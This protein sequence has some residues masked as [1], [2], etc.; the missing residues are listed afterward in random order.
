MVSA[1]DW[2]DCDKQ[3][4]PNPRRTFGDYCD[5]V[6]RVPACSE[7]A[8][9]FYGCLA[10]SDAVCKAVQ[11][12]PSI[13]TNIEAPSCDPGPLVGC[14]MACGPSFKCFDDGTH[15]A[16]ATGEECSSMPDAKPEVDCNALCSPCQVTAG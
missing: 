14:L 2:S 13:S 11:T 7:S 5:S 6:L 12:E 1:V 3:P 10:K 4:I 8:Q 15:C 9:V 16:C